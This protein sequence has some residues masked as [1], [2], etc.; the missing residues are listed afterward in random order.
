MDI[1][2]KVRSPR[3]RSTLAQFA[4][5]WAEDDTYDEFVAAIKAYRH[6]VDA[7]PETDAARPLAPTLP[8]E[9]LRFV[10]ETMGLWHVADPEFRHWLTEET[11]LFDEGGQSAIPVMGFVVTTLVV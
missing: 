4:G 2:V 3:P 9:N 5:M 7:E 6:D 10:R 8:E 1:Q 11:S